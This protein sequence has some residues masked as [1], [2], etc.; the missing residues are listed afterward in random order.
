MLQWI[1][2]AIFAYLGYVFF[3]FFSRKR[4]YSSR[5]PTR[6]ILFDQFF[7]VSRLLPQRIKVLLGHRMSEEDVGNEF[8]QKF[9]QVCEK[10]GAPK[11]A[12][13][14]ATVNVFQTSTSLNGRVSVNDAEYARQLCI[15]RRQQVE[16]PVKG[17]KLLDLYG[18]N[19]VTTVKQEWLKHRTLCN[20]AFSESNNRMV[21]EST[22]QLVEDLFGRWERSLKDNQA[23]INISQDTTSLTLGVIGMAGFGED[24]KGMFAEGERQDGEM[25]TSDI[26]NVTPTLRQCMF[27]LSQH[28]V[29]RMMLPRFLFT[30]P[31]TPKRVRWYG[32]CFDQFE[33]HLR[34]LITVCTEDINNKVRRSDVLGLLVKGYLGQ[35]LDVDQQGGMST[36]DETDAD[37][38]DSFAGVAAEGSKLSLQEVIAD[39]YLF[40]FAGHET[41]A[42]T[43]AVALAL[44]A[45][46][47]EEQKKLQDEVEEVLG[48]EPPTYA[49]VPKLDCAKFVGLEA[50]R[51]VP[52]VANIPKFTEEDTTITSPLAGETTIPKDTFIGLNVYA[53]H[54][55][56]NYWSEPQKFKP[57]R[58]DSRFTSPPEPKHRS[59]FLPFSL[60]QR[61]CIGKFFAELELTVALARMV[62]C[63]EF[64][65]PAGTTQEKLLAWKPILT[66]TPLKD[67]ELIVTKRVR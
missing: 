31:L 11:N 38:R 15:S 59:A 6:S 3:T 16:K 23:T 36:V 61:S 39:S 62:Q 52:P 60:G 19:I 17:Y 33:N 37:S 24:M 64:S 29:M 18:S 57:S 26:T 1:F 66:A 43:L 5:F 47:P 25:P 45:L 41:T 14:I 13:I 48:S 51:M 21:V 8:F 20:P 27:V 63:Y 54:H 58:F 40:F 30:F 49:D 56:P 12:P 67:I 53:L 42:H 34:R 9:D 28:L 44:L 46:H 32:K 22:L 65:V 35:K 10:L 7:V 4:L 2:T 50:L 55:N